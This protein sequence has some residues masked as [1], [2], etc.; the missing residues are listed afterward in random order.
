MKLYKYTKHQIYELSQIGIYKITSIIDNKV[1]IGSAT[2]T[3]AVSKTHKGFYS[4]FKNHVNTLDSNNHRNNHLQNAWNLYGSDNFIFEII[5]FCSKEQS[6]EREIFWID[7]YDACNE[8]K[9]Y[10]YIRQS[11]KNYNS[12]S[13]LT[14]KK[15]SESLK[16]HKPALAT[17]EKTSKS[18]IQYDLN[19]NFIEEFTSMTSAQNKSGAHR[20]AIRR[21]CLGIDKSANNFHWK[22]KNQPI[23]SI[24]KTTW[25]KSLIV[26][27]INT[28]KELKFDSISKCANSLK[29]N[30][31]TIR[32]YINSE[33]LLEDIYLI[34]QI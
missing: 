34:T 3:K 4:R 22:Y 29:Y 31:S 19:D 20:S 8:E 1:Y 28:S 21:V 5:E 2:S 15:I 13:E 16:G 12:T 10:N 26:K 14:R 17:I 27:N 6:D 24:K 23:D 9:G 7:F 33:N 11:L 18:V 32:G 25:R 30:R